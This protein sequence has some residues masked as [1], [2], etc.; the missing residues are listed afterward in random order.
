[1]AEWTRDTG[2]PP[3]ELMRELVSW[4]T[5]TFPRP[6][7]S[8]FRVGAVALG[9]SG[10]LYFGGNLE[11][12]GVGLGSSIH[13]EQSAVQNARAAGETSLVAIATSAAPCG[14]CRQFMNEIDGAADVIVHLPDGPSVPL[15]ELLPRSFGPVD[16]GVPGGLLAPRAN[17]LSVHPGTHDPLAAAALAAA[18][19]AYAPYTDGFAGAA[20]AMNDGSVFVGALLEN[21]AY[22]P[23]LT[24]VAAALNQ[25]ALAGR[26]YAEIARAVLVEVNRAPATQLPVGRALL[27]A[28][29]PAEL[30]V[31]IA[32]V[33]V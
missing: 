29:C 27:A 21:A 15:A 20:L 2:R 25:V 26:D 5:T 6:P 33:D 10:S 30:Q 3:P 12:P 4:A 13:A 9:G 32:G 8:R 17:G 18:N 14:L 11:F 19:A 16:L 23:T 1:M 31:H 22:N 28:L 24:P 7:I